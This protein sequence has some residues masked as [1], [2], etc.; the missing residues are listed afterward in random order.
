MIGGEP[1]L[2]YL[3]VFP[4]GTNQGASRGRTQTIPI[5]LHVLFGKNAWQTTAGIPGNEKP[6][7]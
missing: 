5:S 6:L 4:A 2:I 3:S 1:K 7:F